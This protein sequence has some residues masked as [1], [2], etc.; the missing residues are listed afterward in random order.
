MLTPENIVVL[1]AE[2]QCL[3]ANLP[4]NAVKQMLGFKTPYFR[5]LPS[6]ND[7]LSFFLGRLPTST[8]S[9]YVHMNVDREVVDRRS[10]SEAKQK[11]TRS[12]G[13][14]FGSPCWVSEEKT[15][16]DRFFKRCPTKHEKRKRVY[17]A[18]LFDMRLGRA[19]SGTCKLL[20]ADW[21]EH[22]GK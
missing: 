17:R 3:Q 21:R 6:K 11:T 19:P 4:L 8:L 2:V 18:K 22:R 1:R 12:G 10:T 20:G 15:I 14:C 5:K 16:K 7:T 9:H 13:L